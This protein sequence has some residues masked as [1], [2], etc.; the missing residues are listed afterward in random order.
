MKRTTACLLFFIFANLL[1]HAEDRRLVGCWKAVAYI[2]D[3]QQQPM[4]GLFIFTLL[5]YSANIRFKLA[6][7]PVDDA[8]GNAG[9]YRA[10]GKRIVFTQWV[11]IHIRPHSTTEPVLS[12]EGPDE[13]TDYRLQGKRLVLT[14]PSKNQY[15]LERLEE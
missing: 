2:I 6:P 10:D 3:G 13:G 1:A 8:N 7:G 11:Q 15:I 4:H 5:H 12:R 14:F 9:P